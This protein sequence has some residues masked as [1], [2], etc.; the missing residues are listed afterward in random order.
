[1]EMDEVDAT[2]NYYDF[3]RAVHALL[4]DSDPGTKGAFISTKWR[5]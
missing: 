5:K 1:M 2:L 3:K 4:S